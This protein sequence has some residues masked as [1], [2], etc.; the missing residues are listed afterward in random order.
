[1]ILDLPKYIEH[2]RSG[3]MRLEAKSQETMQ[4][5]LCSVEP[6][7][8]AL[9]ALSHHVKSSVSWGVIPVQVSDMCMKK[10]LDDSHLQE[11]ESPSAVQFSIPG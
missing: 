4:L 3:G 11:F 8:F 10:F 6:G 2:S 5:P 9:G 1:M 7:I